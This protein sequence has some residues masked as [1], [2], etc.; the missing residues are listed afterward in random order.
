MGKEE[1][2]TGREMGIGCGGRRY[3]LFGI[4]RALELYIRELVSIY[5][6]LLASHTWGFMHEDPA[7]PWRLAC[8]VGSL[9][10]LACVG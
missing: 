4:S 5:V 8:T 10:F 7:T 9:A 6:P 3:F 2:A 1:K